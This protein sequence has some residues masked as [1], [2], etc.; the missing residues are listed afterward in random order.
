[1]AARSPAAGYCST[2]PT[3]PGARRCTALHCTALHC[4]DYIHAVLLWTESQPPAIVLLIFV[5]LFTLV[6]LPVVWGYIVVNL[7]CGYLFG[8]LYGLVVTVVTA[9]AGIL[10]A[11]LIILV[12]RT[13]DILKT[14][15]SENCLKSILIQA[16]PLYFTALP[17]GPR[18]ETARILRVHP[19][20]PHR[21]RRPAGR[22]PSLLTASSN[23]TRP[24]LQANRADTPYSDPVRA[25]ERSLLGV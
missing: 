6:S 21:H 19:F 24:G 1:L 14:K 3:S 8:F 23:P 2:P 7:A 4:R 10:M 9:T 16:L 18:A 12:S 15:I 17:G 20:P 13:S 25:A 22:N 5:A 11:H